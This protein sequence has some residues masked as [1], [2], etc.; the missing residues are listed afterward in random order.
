MIQRPL[1]LLFIF[2]ILFSHRLPA[3]TAR[4]KPDPVLQKKLTELVKNFKGEVGIY[5]RHLKTGQT[6]AINADSV[7]PTASMVKVP[8][9]IGVMDKIQRGELHYHDNLV[10]RDSLR[11][12]GEDLLGSFKDSSVVSLSKVMMLMITTSDNTASLWCQQLAG[13]GAAINKLM[14]ANGLRHTRVNSRTSGREA[15]RK[16]YGWGQT[17]PREMAE[18]LVRIREGKVISLAA[19]E[20]IYRNLTRIYW[21]EEAL[22]QIPPYVHVASKQGAVDQSRS[23]VLLVHAP[24]GDYVFCVITK[25]QEDTSWKY[26]NAGFV[27]LRAV[28]QTLWSYFEPKSTWQPALG[29]KKF[30]TE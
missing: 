4:L 13:T 16:M 19:S 17:T 27:L 9:I 30:Y 26:H 18:L 29:V 22:S 2:A 23:E 8:I 21:D 11:Y 14:E 28:S 3:Q 10:Y 1:T 7:F 24:S 12:P 20:R 15:A 25:N 6:V 5:V